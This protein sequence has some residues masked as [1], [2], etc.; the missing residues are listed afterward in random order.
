MNNMNNNKYRIKSKI[1]ESI[2][3]WFWPCLQVWVCSPWFLVWSA[4]TAAAATPHTLP[5]HATN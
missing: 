1:V 5:A 4:P 2:K 3:L